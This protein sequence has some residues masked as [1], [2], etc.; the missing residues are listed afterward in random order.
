[1]QVSCTL[2]ERLNLP[3]NHLEVQS[4]LPIHA[5]SHTETTPPLIFMLH[6]S[7]TCKANSAPHE[8]Q[9]RWRSRL[10]VRMFPLEWSQG[11]TSKA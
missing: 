6:I 7:P 3:A 5:K 1:M 4:I 8:I 10:D 2:N 11:P 9:R